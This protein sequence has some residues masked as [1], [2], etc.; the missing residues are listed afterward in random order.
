[1]KEA[2]RDQWR[3]RHRAVDARSLILPLALLVAACAH[4]ADWPQFRGPA[5][6]GTTPERDLPLKWDAQ[7]G[8]GILW[9][10]A[11][12]KSDNAY[13]SPI[14]VGEKVFVTCASNQPVTHRVLCFAK[15]D[16]KQL[17]ETLIEPGP[18]VLKDFRGG[19]GAPTPCADGERIYV[20]FGSAVIAAVDFAG[21]MV[22]RKELA[23]YAFDVAL[24]SSPVVFR[25]TV[26]L[27]CD[28]TGKTSS[29]VAFDRATG[30]IRWE[31]KRPD[32]GF[33][34]STPVIADVGGQPQMLVSAQKALQG[35]DPASGKVLWWCV[36]PGDAASP[37]FGE[38]LVYSDSGRG[39]KG[40]C[41]DPTG[42]GEVS[43]THVKWTVPQIPEGLSSPVIAGGAV[44]RAHNPE[45]VK[46]LK[47]A[48][49]EANFSERLAGVS[50]WASPFATADGRIYFASAGKTYVLK[51]GD[52][53]ELLA[54][55]N[56]GE[57]NKASAAVS[58]GKIFL[59]GD[60]NL[61]CIGKP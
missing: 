14:V 59:R 33:A 46:G 4:A 15:A 32:T 52:K 37:A 43:A 57:E 20:V 36:V 9:K 3:G 16:G 1:M 21:K 51:A 8:E 11:L 48:T 30:D 24:G 49:G 45:I 55:N 40:V 34:H 54:T 58:D 19:Y 25:D 22:W 53:F 61:Y 7:S 6:V 27:D 60:K 42:A 5:G 13:S 44:W 2:C 50:T 39:G 12:P 41:V 23:N 31:A 10:V 47:L 38:G 29:I 18:W 17:W 56:L 26:I 28:Q 35:L